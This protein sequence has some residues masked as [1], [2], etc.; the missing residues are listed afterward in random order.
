MLRRL[1]NRLRA[2]LTAR[3]FVITALILATA[4]GLTYAFIVW[5]API[6]FTS[7][8]NSELELRSERLL[9]E[10]KQT[11]LEDS[12]PLFNQFI[13]ETGAEVLVLDDKGN[14][15]TLTVPKSVSELSSHPS[16]TTMFAPFLMSVTDDDVT[17]ISTQVSSVDVWSTQNNE[18]VSIMQNSTSYPFTFENSLE[19]YTL[20]V[21]AGV[22]IVNRTK[23]AL[24]Q[25]LPYLALV[26]LAISILGAFFYSRHITKPIVRL[27]AISQ[28]MADFNFTWRCEGNRSDEIGV[29]GRNLDEL[30]RRLSSALD[31]LQN[32]NDALRQEL[33]RKQRL[34]TQRTTFFSAA[35][36]E[37]KTPLTILKGQLSGML[38]GV[39]IY[40]NRDKYLLRSLAVTN[41]MESLV[42][43]M[44]AISK[45]DNAD[46]DQKRDIVDI[47]S[48]IS[49]QMEQN[50]DLAEQKQQTLEAHI[51]PHL[52]V[53]GDG[54]MLSRAVANL[55]TNA[56]FYS[57]ES[58]VISVSLLLDNQIPVLII[59][60]SGTTIPDKDL[61]HLFE[62]FYRVESSRNRESGG[63]GL[64]LYIVKMILDR[65]GASC[66][67]QNSGHH[68]KVTVTFH[69]SSIVQ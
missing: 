52:M 23:Q 6:T 62:A 8:T 51:I 68:V 53:Y 63:S 20:T 32:T 38:A 19:P 59:R 49:F 43:E 50:A 29:L 64:G 39:D 33:G 14:S 46:F 18:S 60:N 13:M 5:A 40:R 45:L 35:S 47:S 24:E 67:I 2:S 11:S 9:T 56:I 31:E 34:E 54:A 16:G 15:V 61:P 22:T 17:S 37:L 10:L 30:S 41:R 58:S 65:H 27:S 21:F 48:T 42:S 25:V 36:H 55:L 57:P 1:I 66:R 3:V 12:G 69:H 26:V 7:I 28:K 44:L 4:C